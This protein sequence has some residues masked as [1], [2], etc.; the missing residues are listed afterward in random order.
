MVISV[1]FSC[2]QLPMSLFDLMP[3][4]QAK[5]TPPF[6]GKDRTFLKLLWRGLYHVESV[7]MNYELPSDYFGLIYEVWKW[8]QIKGKG[9]QRRCRVD[10]ISTRINRMKGKLPHWEWRHIRWMNVHCQCVSR[11]T[12]FLDIWLMDSK[13]ECEV[14][15]LQSPSYRNISNH[16]LRATR[17]PPA[18]RSHSRP[19][20]ADLKKMRSYNYTDST[21]QYS[22][23]CAHRWMNKEWIKIYF[24]REKNRAKD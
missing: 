3:R 17:W 20:T 23:Y 12:R 18:A 22:M 5:T 7:N 4:H 16:N 11:W 8:N 6:G 9:Q 13:L 14:A 19:E 2:D 15:K 24:L 21:V 10:S 1:F